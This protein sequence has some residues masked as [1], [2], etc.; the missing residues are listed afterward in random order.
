MYKM[1]RDKDKKQRHRERDT[2]LVLKDAEQEYGRVIRLL[3]AGRLEVH[4]YDGI[5]RQCIIRGNMRRR[6]WIAAGDLILVS[7]RDW[8]DAKGDVVHRYS[9]EDIRKLQA[10]EAIPTGETFGAVGQEE[11]DAV[12][13]QSES[14]EEVDVDAI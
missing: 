10:M 2:E 3:G 14:D 9:P 5:V 7:K 4:C 6:I 13:F 1:A 11:D 8:Q 12:I